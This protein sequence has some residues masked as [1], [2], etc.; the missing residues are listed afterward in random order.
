LKGLKASLICL[1]LM[2]PGVSLSLS[3][4]AKTFLAVEVQVQGDASPWRWWCGGSDDPLVLRSWRGFW[5]GLESQGDLEIVSQLRNGVVDVHPMYCQG[6]LDADMARNL[7]GLLGTDYVW[8]GRV[9]ISEVVRHDDPRFHTTLIRYKELPSGTLEP[10]SASD[11]K[12]VAG[13]GKPL[14]SER[15]VIAYRAK[16]IPAQVEE[17]SLSLARQVQNLRLQKA[18]A[19]RR[20][21][22]QMFLVKDLAH[23]ESGQWL[24][25]EMSTLIPASMQ[26]KPEGFMGQN[27]L[28]RLSAP[29]SKTGDL[30]DILRST[31][32]GAPSDVVLSFEG[33]TVEGIPV[34]RANGAP[35]PPWIPEV[36]PELEPN[37]EPDVTE[38]THDEPEEQEEWKTGN[39]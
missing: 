2:A 14:W 21:R 35:L 4:T 16:D 15:T 12:G 19:G 25:Q 7:A 5:K 17:A 18:A 28:F 34:F 8:Y 31:L 22:S 6:K 38:H 24:I 23:R 20:L 9:E 11:A 33:T 29:R 3:D 39:E 30:I 1:V 32:E 36:E 10:G 26:I 37:N 27:A 13:K